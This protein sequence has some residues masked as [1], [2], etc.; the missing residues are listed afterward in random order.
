[1]LDFADSSRS[2]SSTSAARTTRCA[3]CASSGGAITRAS[4]IRRR[5][6]AGVSDHRLPVQRSGHE[7]AVRSALRRARCEE[8]RAATA[9]TSRHGVESRRAE[10]DAARSAD[11][12]RAHPLPRRDRRDR[13]GMR[14]STIE[15][16]G[17]MR[18]MRAHGTIEALQALED[19]KMLPWRP[20][21]RHAGH[22]AL[23]G[24]HAS[25]DELREA[26]TRRSMRRRRTTHSGARRAW[27][28]RE[29]ALLGAEVSVPGA[30][31][32]V[33]GENFT[34]SLSHQS[35]IP[36]VA[37]PKLRGLGRHPALRCCSENLPGAF[38][39]TAGVF[40]SARGED[41]DAH[42]R[43]RG[44]ARSAPTGASTTSRAARRRSA[45]RRRSIP[46]RSTA[47]T[48][49]RG[50]TST[51]R[52]ATP[53]CRSRLLDDMK[54]LYS[55]FDLARPTTS[56]SMTINGP[57]PMLLAFFM[58]AAIDQQ[59]EKYLRAN[60]RWPSRRRAKIDALYRRRAAGIACRVYQGELPDG[61]RRPRARAARRHGRRGRR[62]PTSTRRSAP[63]RSRRCAAPCRRTS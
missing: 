15:R 1:M 21:E 56:V 46:S 48:R 58:N 44:R 12:G 18:R 6:R 49:T 29:A 50:R 4:T 22:R 59:C 35:A 2:T 42:V 38:P 31:Q 61:Q 33:T 41:P 27:P 36:K 43:G 17:A 63:T 40:P 25:L 26:Y 57:A 20:L 5:R 30:R 24:E 55:G 51:A 13:R 10:R 62:P 28:A 34:E 3:T 47:R 54:K 39:Y 8:D 60:G 16:A 9:G 37:L 45:S 53:A 19:K 32:S 11:S 23:E 7:P 52:P 14:R